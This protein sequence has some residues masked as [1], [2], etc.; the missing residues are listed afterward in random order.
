MSKVP[1]SK[2]MNTN[3]RVEAGAQVDNY[4]VHRNCVFLCK[5]PSY[6]WSQVCSQQQEG[7]VKSPIQNSIHQHY[8]PSQM[9][10]RFS[11]RKEKDKEKKGSALWQ[12]WWL[13]CNLWWHKCRRRNHLEEVCSLLC[14]HTNHLPFPKHL[15]DAITNLLGIIFPARYGQVH[16]QVTLRRHG[17]HG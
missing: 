16:P 5:K 2:C 11:K 8:C 9:S 6:T 14:A 12:K 17:S 4:M 15:S 10:I 13:K 3:L 1:N 7:F